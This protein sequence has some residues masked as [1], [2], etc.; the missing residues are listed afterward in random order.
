MKTLYLVMAAI[1]LASHVNAAPQKTEAPTTSPTPTHV[2]PDFSLKSTAGQ[3][4]KLSDFKG[5]VVLINFWASWCGPCRQEM[6]I[7][8]ALYKANKDTGLVVLG[9]NL[10]VDAGERTDFLKDNPVSF[11][12]LEDTKMKDDKMAT[13]E[14]YKASVQPSSFFVDRTGN[15]VHTHKGFKAGDDAVYAATVKELL[16]K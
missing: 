7:L 10:D 12:V 6:P 4:V 13:A 15:L 1:F 5:K 14:L 3:T 11:T 9:I 2:A 16:A 8:D